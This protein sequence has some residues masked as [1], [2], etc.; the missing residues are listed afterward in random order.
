MLLLFLGSLNQGS[1]ILNAGISLPSEHQIALQ[2][3]LK[4]VQNKP[5]PVMGL[6]GS[7]SSPATRSSSAGATPSKL[8]T[9]KV[10]CVY[11]A[12]KKWKVRFGCDGQETKVWKSFIIAK[13]EHH[14]LRD[15]GFIFPFIS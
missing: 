13:F 11:V 3:I 9:R 10:S 5:E 1:S 8:D 15:W 6:E 7:S 2:D 14:C 4:I 12:L